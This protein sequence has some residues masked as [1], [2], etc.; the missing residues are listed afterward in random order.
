MACHVN[1][2]KKERERENGGT[3]QLSSFFECALFGALLSYVDRTA[4]RLSIII[5]T[6]LAERSND[7]RGALSPSNGNL[8][9]LA[10]LGRHRIL[11][12]GQLPCRS[13]FHSMSQYAV[14]S[15]LFACV[16]D[17]RPSG[18]VRVREEEGDAL[19]FSVV[20]NTNQ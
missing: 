2:L 9:S 3:K 20:C 19:L 6:P 11:R 7:P 13:R 5:H 4:K 18:Q 15:L 14:R 17:V 1:A 12:V 16:I 10:G 8:A